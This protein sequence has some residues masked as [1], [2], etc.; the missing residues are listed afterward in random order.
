MIK[1][2]VRFEKALQ[3]PE[4]LKALNNLAI[5]LSA[6]GHEVTDIYGLFENFLLHL[7]NSGEKKEAEEELLMEVMDALTGWCHPN[8]QLIMPAQS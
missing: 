7:R 5:E 6:E 8:V 3:S 1:S 2:E 4:P